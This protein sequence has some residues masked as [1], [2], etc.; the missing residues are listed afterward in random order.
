M[1]TVE[2]IKIP[3]RHQTTIDYFPYLFIYQSANH[4]E[5]NAPNIDHNETHPA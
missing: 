5:T 2:N 1:P 3:N 4:Y